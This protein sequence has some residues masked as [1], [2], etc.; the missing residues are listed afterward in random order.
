[1]HFTPEYCTYQQVGGDED[2]TGARAEL[3]HH[4][5]SRLLLHVAMLLK[6]NLKKW[7]KPL[8][9]QADQG[10]KW[11]QLDRNERYHSRNGE[12][13]AQQLVS[14]PVHFP[15][16]V[17]EDDGLSDGQGLVQVTQRGQLPVLTARATK[18]TRVAPA[19]ICSHYIPD[20]SFHLI[21]GCCPVKNKHLHS[22]LVFRSMKKIHFSQTALERKPKNGLNRCN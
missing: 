14:E 9:H 5:V 21:H 20:S 13:L 10:K 7:N 2:S 11:L 12:V 22:L 17:D 6:N 4:H 18:F 8:K 19:N 3:L 1:M 16:R 15:P